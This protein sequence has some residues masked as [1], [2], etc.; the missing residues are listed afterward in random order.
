MSADGSPDRRDPE[1][2]DSGQSPPNAGSGGAAAERPVPSPAAPGA[3]REPGGRHAAPDPDESTRPLWRAPDRD[4]PEPATAPLPAL[5]PDHPTD[6][7][8]RLAELQ[9]RR[10]AIARSIAARRARSVAR[11]SDQDDEDGEYYRRTSWLI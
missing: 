3:T 8:R 1:P 9:E 2:L 6:E 4:D 7:Q 5:A 11:P 10:E